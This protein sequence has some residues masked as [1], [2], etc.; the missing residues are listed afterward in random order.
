MCSHLGRPDGNKNLKYTLAPVAD[1]L[2][3]LLGKDIKFLND[4]VGPEVEAACNI[5]F[6]KISFSFQS[7]EHIF[8]I[9]F[10]FLLIG[11]D[12]APGSI[13][14]L[15]NLRF[16]LEEEGKG[17]D[18]N[19]A[20]AKADPAKVKSFRESLRKLADIYVNVRIK[21]LP[22]AFGK[23]VKFLFD[24]GCRMLLEL[25][26]VHIVL[27]LEKVMKFVQLAYY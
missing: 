15:E 24:F 1:E 17:V 8:Q 12:P 18:A 9:L 11:Q 10:L 14:L 19:G 2:K 21:L 5:I 22:L 7:L 4:C 26:I 3:K 25:L 23:K 13:I 27:C 6:N 20:K 16:Y